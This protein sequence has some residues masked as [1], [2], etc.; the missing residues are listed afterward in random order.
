MKNVII[1]V[2][3]ISAAIISFVLITSYAKEQNIDL[4]YEKSDY[5]APEYYDFDLE[6]QTEPSQ[7]MNFWDM[8]DALNTTTAETLIVTDDEGNIVTDEEGNPVTELPDPS[9][10]EV[11]GEE[12]IQENTTDVPNESTEANTVELKESDKPQGLFIPQ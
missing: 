5:S 3:L 11:P 6:L 7:T 9:V 4:K 2:S 8:V 1:I 10:T 12:I